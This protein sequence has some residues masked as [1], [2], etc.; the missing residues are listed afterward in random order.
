[1]RCFP[2]DCFDSS[3][4]RPIVGFVLFAFM[5]GFL[6]IHIDV[7]HHGV[8]EMTSFEQCIIGSELCKVQCMHGL[9]P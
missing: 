8:Y 7:Y 6:L 1:M 4:Q 2:L 5:N 9:T 3:L